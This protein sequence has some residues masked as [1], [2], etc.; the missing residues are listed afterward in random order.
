MTRFNL[1]LKHEGI[2]TSDPATV[3]TAIL[4][5]GFDCGGLAQHGTVRM[6]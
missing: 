4:V 3:F 2:E 5:D 6:H 1:L